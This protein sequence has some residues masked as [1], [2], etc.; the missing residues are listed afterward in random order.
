MLLMLV[1][2]T[3]NATGQLGPNPIGTTSNATR[4]LIVPSPYAF[5][6]WAPIYIGLIIFPVYQIIKNRNNHPAWVE[7]RGWYAANVVANGL[8]LAASSYDWQWTTVGII[9]FMLISLFRINQLRL[10]GRS[11]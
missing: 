6:I 3:L 7:L 1:L 11:L 2:Y 5:A 10:P 9:V 4:P 8:W